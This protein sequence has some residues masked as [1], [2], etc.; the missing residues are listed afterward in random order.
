MKILITRYYGDERTA[1]SRMLVVDDATGCVR[2]ECEAREATFVD[3]GSGFKGCSKVCLPVGEFRCK[4]K[5]TDLSP[6][7]V[8]VSDAPGHKGCRIG[9]HDVAQQKCNEVLVGVSDEY[10]KA[11]WRR[12]AGQEDTFRVFEK[13]VYAAFLNGEGILLVVRNEIEC[14]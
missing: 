8:V 14:V 1:K 12:I 5:S 7:T 2:L 3:Y 4:V 13:L 10:P 11:K 6:M 9:W